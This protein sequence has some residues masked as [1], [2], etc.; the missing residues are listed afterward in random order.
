MENQNVTAEQSDPEMLDQ[1]VDQSKIVTVNIDDMKDLGN[2]E[3]LLSVVGYEPRK[4]N[5]KEKR[6]TIDTF[7]N[8]PGKRIPKTKFRNI[9]NASLFH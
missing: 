4:I 2:I 6:K 5:R 7:N 8:D 3:Y 1:R 9:I